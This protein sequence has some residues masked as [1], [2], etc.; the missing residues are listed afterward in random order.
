[1]MIDSR[2]NK[3]IIL[4]RGGGLVVFNDN[5]T[6]DDLSDD[7]V[8]RLDVNEGNG[9]LPTNNVFSISE[10]RDGA[11]W[12]GTDKGIAVIYSPQNIFT[13][14]NFDAQQ[15]LIQQ[16][17]YT[18]VLLENETVTSIYVDGA[19]RKWFGTLGGG[20]F[21]MSADGTVEI[22]HFSEQNS[23]LLSNVITSIAIHPGT[24]EVFFGTERGI[25]SYKSTATEGNPTNDGI[26]VYPN[27]VRRDFEGTIGIN[28]LVANASVKITDIS[29][30]LIYETIAHGGQAVWNGKN[31]KGERANTGVYLVFVSN[32]DGKK[33]QVAKLLF[34][35]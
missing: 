9:K 26:Y 31:F 14:N 1:M 15:I 24:G 21:L 23:P 6:I 34:L 20:A 12:I 13:G 25:I 2:G 29:G 5:G 10:D 7:L 4:G 30:T 28:G 18:Q 32:A 8:K 33:T 11:I 35:N 19:N 22:N 3:W 16:D 17:G 27:P